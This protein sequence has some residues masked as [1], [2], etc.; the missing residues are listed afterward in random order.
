MTTDYFDE[1][2]AAWDEKPSRVRLAR[3]VG[4]AIVCQAT[5]TRDMTVLDYG[6]G[7]GLLGLYLLPHVRSVTGADSSPGML[8]VLSRKIAEGGLE[9]MKAVRLDLE[10]DPVP[11][12]R[13]NMIVTSMVMH[14]V[15]DPDEIIR[16][17]HKMLLPGGFLCLADLDT[18][19]GTFH[20]TEAAGSVHHHGFDRE[21]MKARL[22]R[23]GF[24]EARDVTAL[25]YSKLVEKGGEEEFSV[26]LITAKRPARGPADGRSGA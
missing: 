6:C 26:F 19:P 4:E 15:T 22:A 11:D 24:S 17:F 7:T 14:H 3:A 21:D 9:N 18:E 10:R 16:A 23:I 13:Y 8:D 20:T 5:P 12:G 1:E 2:A 25:R